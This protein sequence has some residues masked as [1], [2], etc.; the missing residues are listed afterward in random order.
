MKNPN[1]ISNPIVVKKKPQVIIQNPE[2][3]KIENNRI[4]TKD[5]VIRIKIVFGVREI[6]AVYGVGEEV[7]INKFIK[8]VIREIAKEYHVKQNTVKQNMVVIIE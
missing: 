3:V 4:I 7:D 1:Q 5:S 6:I 8:Y 2:K